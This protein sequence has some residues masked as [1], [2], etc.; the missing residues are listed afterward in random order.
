MAP[1][2]SVSRYRK[3]LLASLKT[4]EKLE[5]CFMTSLAKEGLA[6]LWLCHIE[7]VSVT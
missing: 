3:N 5:S 2:L 4:E 7:W 6:V 1:L